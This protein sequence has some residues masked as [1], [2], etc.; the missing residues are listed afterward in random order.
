MTDATQAYGDNIT[1]SDVNMNIAIKHLGGRADKL[2]TPF[3][4]APFEYDIEPANLSEYDVLMLDQPRYKL[5]IE[6]LRNTNTPVVYRVRGNIWK[7]MDIW[8]FGR[9]KKVVAENFIYPRLDGAIAVDERLA[10]IFSSHTGVSPVGAAGLA[11][12]RSEWENADHDSQELSLI[13]LTNFNYRQKVDPMK[14]YIDRVDKWLESNG[15]H[16]YL[17]G[18]GLHDDRFAAFTDSYENVSYAGYIEPQEWLPEMDAMLHISEF[19]AYPNAILEGFASK[20]PVLTNDFAA[21]KREH[22]PNVTHHS[23]EQLLTTLEELTKPAYRD[24][25]GSRG[26]QYIGE[27][28]TPEHIGKQY[29]DYFAQLIHDSN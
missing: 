21:F 16:W 27:Y 9:A 14:P 17:C 6:V 3:D 28:H 19:D 12:Q 4:A 1:Y 15:G 10:G 2:L 25:L 18:E 8:R 7:E 23:P 22:A 29:A 20:L 13:T 11:K 5:A 26:L 24:D